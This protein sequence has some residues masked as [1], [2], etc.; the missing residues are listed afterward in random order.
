M[1]K[2]HQG[3]FRPI[4]PHK[5]EG[6]ATNIIYRSGWEL[7]LFSY[8]DRHPQVKRWSSEEVIIPYISPI[9]NK[10]HRYFMDAKVVLDR[11]NGL[12]ETWLIEVKP[13]KQTQPP[14]VKE[15]PNKQYI[16]EVKTWGIN[17]AKWQAAESYCNTR[18]WKFVIF[19]EDHLG[20][21]K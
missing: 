5:Y 4:N 20:I 16:T 7:K 9:D 10:R 15:K 2:Y 8:L 6:D 17:S 18:G 13:K 11:G 12:T 21:K 1:A 19:T 14:A 3:I